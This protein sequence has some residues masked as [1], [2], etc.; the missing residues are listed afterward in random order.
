MLVMS[1]SPLES[2]ILASAFLGQS[3]ALPAVLGVL[4][5]IAGVAWVVLESGQNTKDAQ[6][7]PHRLRGVLLSMGAATG[8]AVGLVLS[9]VGLSGNFPALSGVVIRMLAAAA[10]LWVMTW[11]QRQARPTIGRLSQNRGAIPAL[12][13]G[14][15]VGPY[16]GVW[17]S[18][19]AVQFAPLGIASTLM[20][21][22][23]VFLMPISWFLYHERIG[24]QGISGTLLAT[25]GVAM[26]FLVT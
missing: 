10:A 20:A 1:I 19:V 9:K 24:W 17:L 16:I 6:R 7:N 2:A 3:L 22:P 12:I 15:A 13:G 5:T 26:L 11:F 25:A 4:V 21:L 18:L 8:Q 23:P 14:A